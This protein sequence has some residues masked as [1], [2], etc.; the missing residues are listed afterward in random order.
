MK[1]ANRTRKKCYPRS[2]AITCWQLGAELGESAGWGCG[3]SYSVNVEGVG[4][5]KVADTGAL[6]VWANCMWQDYVFVG[7]MA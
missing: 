6:L 4:S 3:T 5:P 1:A 2:A 7:R